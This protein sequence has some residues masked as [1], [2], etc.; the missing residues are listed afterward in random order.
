MTSPAALLSIL[1]GLG[2]DV[3]AGIELCG[4]DD[5]FYCDLIRELHSDVLARR[6]G[7][8]RSADLVARREYAH[9]LKGTLQVLGERGAALR[10]RDLEQMLRSG[11]RGDDL[12]EG[13]LADLDRI[14]AALA[15]HF[16][17]PSS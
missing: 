5:L 4:G 2:F 10:A 8:L 7:A 16:A 14:D 15:E 9:L 6:N 13:L 11:E 3:G 12:A 1:A 17:Q